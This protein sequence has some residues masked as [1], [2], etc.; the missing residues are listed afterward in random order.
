MDDR[1]SVDDALSLD[2]KIDLVIPRGSSELVQHIT[3]TAEGRMPI[4]GHTEGVCHVYI[5][6]NADL[7]KAIDIGV[8]ALRVR[9][10]TF[11]CCVFVCVFVCMSVYGCVFVY[12]VFMYICVCVCASLCCVSVC[13]YTETIY[14]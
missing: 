4:L 2:G 3:K 14:M 7:E 6:Q 11:L 13:H 1:E 8:C 5:D 12:C 9:V 10:Y